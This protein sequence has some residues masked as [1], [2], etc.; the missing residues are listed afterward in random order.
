MEDS[1]IIDLLFERSEQAIE[2]LDKQFGTVVKKTAS[3][4][5]RNSQ[6]VE[7]C[8][9]DTW[10]AVWNSVPP[11]RPEPLGSYVCRIARN[12]AV[13]RLR[14]KTAAKRDGGFEL[15][16]DELAECVPSGTNLERELEARELLAAVNRFLSAM[17]YDD[18][19]VFVRRY[20]YADSVRDIAAAMRVREN[21]VSLRLFRLREK[22][23]KKLQ[24][25]GLL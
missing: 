21:Q 5:L 3:N 8:A 9:N 25:E 16:L 13:S 19:F 12:L 23:R 20:W 11:H 1:K 4:I 22:L 18:R 10:L 14:T 2:A 15:V 24:K 6:D 17:E 7:E